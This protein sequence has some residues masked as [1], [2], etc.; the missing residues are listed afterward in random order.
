VKRGEL[1]R[2]KRPTKLDP[3]GFRIFVIVSR[4]DCIESNYKSVICAAIYTNR[5]GLE[6]EVNVGIDDGLKHE[7]AI[8]CDELLSIPKYNLTHF[9]GSLSEQRIAELNQAL[10]IALE[11]K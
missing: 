9:I 6:S 10:K 5:N 3:K 8:R 4:Q 7:S 11:L 1:Y 2:V